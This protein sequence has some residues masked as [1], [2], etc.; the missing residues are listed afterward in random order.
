M[1]CPSPWRRLLAI[2]LSG[3]AAGAA[4]QS[5][6][7]PD[8][9]F[10]ARPVT[11]I[12]PFPAGGPS[13][14]LA[15]GIAQKMSV[16][17][18]QPVV[19]ENL[20]GANGVIG[21]NKLLKAAPDG[22]TI[23]FGGIGTH[24]ANVA[25]YKKPPYDPVADFAPI[26][27]AG[28]APMLLLA[29]ADLPANNLPEFVAWLRDHHANASYGSAGVGSIS[30]YGCVLLLSAI[31][32]NPT[33]IPYRGVAPAINDLMGGQTDFMCDQTITALPQIAGGRIKAVAVLASSRLAQLPQ[34]G[35]ATEAGF[36][37][38]A[39]SWNALFAPRGT[40]EAVLQRLTAALRAAMADGPLRAQMEA[41]SVLLPQPDGVTPAAV[42]KLIEHGLRNDVPALKAKGESLN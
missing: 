5:A 36:P 10:P 40:P 32:Q 27:P 41:L 42:S 34:V 18:E 38:D 21:L 11:L 22:Y 25:L 37:L 12:V 1:S 24:V 15:R 7:P 20:G 31:Q 4:A 8:G 39:R 35:T 2:C 13:D 6:A 19:I 26:G 29:R 17:L 16:Q 28:S 14:A 3:L 30:H 23:A 9:A 33:H